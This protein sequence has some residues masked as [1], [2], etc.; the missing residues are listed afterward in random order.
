[1]REDARTGGL[2]VVTTAV[3]V[4]LTLV[5]LAL[6]RNAVAAFSIR[7]LPQVAI[8]AVL[9]WPVVTIYRR[10]LWQPDQ[11]Q[12]WHRENRAAVAGTLLL[13]PVSL[14]AF[15]HGLGPV[16]GLVN[17][18]LRAGAGPMYAASLAYHD[19]GGGLSRLL[20]ETGRITLELVWLYLL[21]GMGASILGR[22]GE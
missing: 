1:M 6:V 9:L 17:L 10:E 3:S 11:L 13:A 4:L 12:T 20:F 8:A 5:A 22:D 15:H 16:G 14:L 21:A 18:P 7:A 2:F 19:I